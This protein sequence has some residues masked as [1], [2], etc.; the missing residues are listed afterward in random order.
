MLNAEKIE[1]LPMMRLGVSIATLALQL[2]M[3]MIICYVY[4]F[5]L[6]IYR[7]CLHNHLRLLYVKTFQHSVDVRINYI[8]L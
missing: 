8:R 2:N 5:M 3:A 1:K 6:I 4:V 7:L